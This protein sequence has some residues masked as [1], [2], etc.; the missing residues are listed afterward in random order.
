M[1][2]YELT[3]PYSGNIADVCPV[4]AMT[5]RDFRFKCRVWFLDSA[6]S[7][8]P[9][10]SRGCNIEIHYNAHFN[11]R[12]HDQRVHRLKPRCNEAVNGYWICDEGRYSYPSIDA[13]NRLKT[14]LL[15]QGGTHQTASWTQAMQ[16]IAG[17]LKQVLATH[18]PQAA[19]VL[20]SPQMSNEE[21]FLVRRIFKEQLK[22]E[23][24]E[25]RFPSNAKVHSDDFLIT[26]DKNPNSKG[27]ETL[28][29]SGPG[30][31]SLLRACAEGRMHFPDILRHR[32]TSAFDPKLVA[33]ALGKVECVVFQGSWDQP[34]AA[35]ADVQL[36]AAVYAEKDGTFTNVQG[37]VQRFKAAVPPIGESLP[38]VDILVQLAQELGISV[39]GTAADQIF[40][41]IGQTVEAFAGMTWQTVGSGGQVL[42][43]GAGK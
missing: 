14:P 5:D 38:D 11:P 8:C 28:Y 15:K 26:A 1:P 6:P 13:P 43:S 10:C 19:A 33:D 3:N 32:L 22:I 35:L 17:S 27:V 25:G 20:I 21:L 39:P 29:S 42:K 36:P 16:E 18:G 2:G 34:A 12:Y 37:R 30:A 23:N 24:I 4:G 7:V 9:G 41:E 31:E 40:A